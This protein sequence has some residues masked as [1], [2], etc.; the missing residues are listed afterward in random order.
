VDCVGHGF[1]PKS[2]LLEIF[3]QGTGLVTS[4]IKVMLVVSALTSTRFP[5]VPQ[6]LSKDE[7]RFKKS[8]NSKYFTP[9]GKAAHSLP[10][11]PY[12]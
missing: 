2:V 7:T 9:C 1:V 12:F 11:N 3:L 10:S 6:R 8:C 4:F 5:Y